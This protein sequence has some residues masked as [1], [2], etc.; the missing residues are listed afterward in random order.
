MV[1][2]KFNGIY[3]CTRHGQVFKKYTQYF[4][5]CK[6]TENKKEEKKVQ[7]EE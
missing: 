5:K 7:P 1:K 4:S 6:I 2:M 3:E